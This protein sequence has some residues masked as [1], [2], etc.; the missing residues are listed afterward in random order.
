MIVITKAKDNS[1]ILSNGEITRGDL[2]SLE[3]IALCYWEYGIK[4]DIVKAAMT[5]TD[6]RKHE[7]IIFNNNTEYTTSKI[8]Y[9][10]VGKEE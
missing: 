5:F 2:N 6:A 7:M 9:S 4:R 10:K 8:D 1:Y 3:V